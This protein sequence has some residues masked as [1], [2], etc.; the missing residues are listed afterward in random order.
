MPRRVCGWF[1]YLKRQ[2][3]ELPATPEANST[4]PQRYFGRIHITLRL[5]FGTRYEADQNLSITVLYH[6]VNYHGVVYQVTEG[7]SCMSA[8][9]V[10]G[11]VCARRLVNCLRLCP[12]DLGR[13]LSPQT[14]RSP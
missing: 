10:L 7:A 1:R 13:R 9:Y 3:P 12:S 2:L 11:Y 8:C 14:R 5:D 6:E 4:T